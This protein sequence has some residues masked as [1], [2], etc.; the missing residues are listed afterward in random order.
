MNLLIVSATSYEVKPLL[1]YLEIPHPVLGMN[2]SS[3][4]FINKE[5][6]VHVLI[7]GIGMVNTALMVGRYSIINVDLAINAGV[8]GSFHK[9]L[10]LGEIVN[11]TDDIL[12]EMGAENDVDFL[13]Y[14][15]LQLD[16]EHTFKS[17]NTIHSEAINT[18]KKAK[19]ITVNTVH[20]NDV[21]IAKV[22][23]LY[24]PDVESME[25]A[26]F[27]AACKNAGINHSQI[28]YNNKPTSVSYPTTVNY[29]QLR[30]I[31]NYVEKRDKSKWNMP[32]AIA[33]LNTFL[34]NYIESL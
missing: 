28:N 31:S 2:V 30:A 13:T 34:V 21:S 22:T 32:L 11:I 14:D 16:G 23:A 24:N 7:T 1:Q 9:N 12:S 26:A 6:D 29:I 18:L 5:M 17:N 10:A 15:Q 25:G 4:S 33:N 3:K 8:C 20:G 27:F 19:G